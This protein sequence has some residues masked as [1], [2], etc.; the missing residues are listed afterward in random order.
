[1]YGDK[2][3]WQ[4][5][6]AGIWKRVL[7]K[8]GRAGKGKESAKKKERADPETARFVSSFGRKGVVLSSS[9]QMSKK[10]TSMARDEIRLLQV[11]LLQV[12]WRFLRSMLV[13]GSGALMPG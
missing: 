1:M 8:L 6:I 2:D 13:E 3:R 10:F 9:P 11:R 4:N 5:R 7:D 12:S